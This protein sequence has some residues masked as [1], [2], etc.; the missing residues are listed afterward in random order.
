PPLLFSEFGRPRWSSL[1]PYTTLFR[2][3]FG[4]ASA[5]FRG[6]ARPYD[7]DASFGIEVDIPFGEE[8]NRSINKGL[9]PGRIGGVCVAVDLYIMLDAVLDDLFGLGEVLRILTS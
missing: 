4:D 7:A 1:F 2:S 5:I 6:I 8:D 3:L 9:E